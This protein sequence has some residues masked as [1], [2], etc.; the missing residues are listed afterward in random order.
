ML[1]TGVQGAKRQSWKGANPRDILKEAMDANPGASKESLLATVRDELLREDRFEYLDAVIEYWFA[2]NYHSLV[3]PSPTP[4]DVMARRAV[5]T[6]AKERAVSELKKKVQTRIREEA[7]AIQLDF[8]MPS[9]KAL[10]DATGA[11]CARAGGWFTKISAK[12]SA[13][14]RVGSVLSEDQVRK[15]WRSR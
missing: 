14:Q 7:E 4:K 3:K 15:I 10:R 11:E 5:S 8:V 9:G 13:R 6:A 12:V 1:N 2:N